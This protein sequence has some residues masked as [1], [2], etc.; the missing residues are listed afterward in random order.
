MRHRDP[1]AV[2]GLVYGGG[3]AWTTSLCVVASHRDVSGA[4]CG[5]WAFLRTKT[6]LL[7]EGGCLQG[8]VEEANAAATAEK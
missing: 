2:G 1:A 8:S 4:P 3:G 6:E 5:F 7:R